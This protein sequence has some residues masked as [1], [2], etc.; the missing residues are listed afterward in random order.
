MADHVEGPLYYERMGRTGPV[1]AFVHPN[2]MDQSCWI[3]QM[4][5]LSTWYRCIAIDIPGY[6]RSPKATAGLTMRDMAAA[7]WEAIDDAFGAKDGG[8]PA[9]LVGCSVGSIILP[10]MFH[11]RPQKTAALIL[12]GGP[13]SALVEG[14][15]RLDPAIVSSGVPM[16]GICYGMQLLARELDAELV[17]LDHAE[18]GPATLRVVSRQTPLFDDV[19]DALRVWMSHGD[20]VVRLP[21]GFST[22]ASTPRCSVAANSCLLTRTSAAGLGGGG[23]NTTTPAAGGGGSALN[24]STFTAPR[25]GGGAL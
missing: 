18:Y 9:I 11:H 23:G 19:P 25:G 21:D 6:G 13:E 1:M 2:P 12:S 15:P 7:S 5:H 4:A 14:A 10:H 8:E 17:K 3:F 16:L 20:S 24:T 22:L